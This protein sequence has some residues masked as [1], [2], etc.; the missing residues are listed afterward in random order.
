MGM[1]L[2]VPPPCRAKGFVCFCMPSRT[3]HAHCMW[4]KPHAYI[5][6]TWQRT[7]KPSPCMWKLLVAAFGGAP[8]LIA[9]MDG[10]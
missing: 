7:S 5:T 1:F 10:S 8:K 9:C 4:A 6:P 3:Q 2:E